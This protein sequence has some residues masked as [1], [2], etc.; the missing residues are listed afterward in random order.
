[1]FN[2]QSLLSLDHSTKE[3]IVKALP[4]S[5]QRA[6]KSPHETTLA[7][8]RSRLALALKYTILP[9]AL[10]ATI[11]TLL[12][13]MSF[14]QELSSWL[15]LPHLETASVPQPGNKAPST[16]QLVLP[17]GDAKPAV[18]VFLRHCGCPCDFLP[19]LASY[20]TL[21]TLSIV[22]EKTFH[23]MRS[24]AESYPDIHFIAISHSDRQA[25]DKWVEAVGGAGGVGVI[26][27]ANRTLYAQWG[28][29]VSG[30]W[31][32]LS[33]W[34]MWSVFSLWRNEKISNRP[35][36]SGSR[37]QTSGSFV[38]DGQGQVTWGGAA[39]SADTIPDF[40][41]AVKSVR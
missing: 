27:D 22:A 34:S 30:W 36:E 11:F 37:W 15:F 23:L 40:D 2:L 6:I 19:S 29:G 20:V 18:I 35:T 4:C 24:A 41:A 7:T 14:R 1:M 26:V 3:A 12:R 39:P 16:V 5:L 33:P 10:L 21:L 8:T 38:V 17:C 25:T 9:S 32:V 13:I 28:L 31:H